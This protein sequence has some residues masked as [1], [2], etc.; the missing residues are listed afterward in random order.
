MKTFEERAR[1]LAAGMS[2][3]AR[4]VVPTGLI[5][6]LIDICKTLDQLTQEKKP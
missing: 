1:Q 3:T 2:K 4:A 5:T 6:L